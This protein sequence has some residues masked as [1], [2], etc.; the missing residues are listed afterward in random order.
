MNNSKRRGCGG[1]KLD[2]VLKINSANG[3]ARGLK[4][5]YCKIKELFHIKI[6]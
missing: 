1:A 2:I 6:C 3:H 4:T 5:L